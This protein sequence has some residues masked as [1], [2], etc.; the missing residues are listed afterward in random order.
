MNDIVLDT[1]KKGFA[2]IEAQAETIPEDRYCTWYLGEME[3]LDAVEAKIKS[4][5]E[6]MLKEIQNRKQS[7]QYVCGEKFRGRVDAALAEIPIGKD[8]KPKKKSIN[9]HT[10]DA[11]YRMGTESIRFTDERS[12]KEWAAN[13]F[14]LDQLFD[15]IGSVEKSPMVVAFIHRSALYLSIKSLNKT[16]F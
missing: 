2:E 14:D 13:N 16:L 9:Y 11:G 7:L 12:A 4:Q 3:K 8:G 1:L 5:T 15:A 6:V 10:G